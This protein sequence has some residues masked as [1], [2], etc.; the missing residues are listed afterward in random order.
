MCKHVGC[1]SGH[2]QHTRS[3]I[4]DKLGHLNAKSGTEKMA[5]AKHHDSMNAKDARAGAI[6]ACFST[7]PREERNKIEHFTVRRCAFSGSECPMP[8]FMASF[9]VQIKANVRRLLLRAVDSD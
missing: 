7:A 9:D 4:S 5:N 2:R 1:A 8:G 3:I 6:V